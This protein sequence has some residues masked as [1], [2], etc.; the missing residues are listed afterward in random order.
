MSP[1]KIEALLKQGGRYDQEVVPDLEAHVEEQLKTGT[2]DADANLALLKLYLLHPAL[3][4][5]DVIESILLKA[6][7]AF[8]STHFSMCMFQIPEKHHYALKD[9]VK[10]S[11]Q[12]EMAKFKAFWK[13]SEAITSLQKAAGWQESVRDFI[14]GVISTMYRTIREEQL[15]EALNLPAKELDA[16]VKKQGWSRS[17]E[18]KAIITVNTA[19]FESASQVGPKGP[20]NMTMDQYKSLFFAAAV[21]AA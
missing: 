12:L 17:K 6:M 10:L 14:A 4:K 9:V 7:M 19:S 5:P 13:D 16:R 20:S 15:L 2:H 8:P 18:D 3:T 21:T 11:Q 1:P